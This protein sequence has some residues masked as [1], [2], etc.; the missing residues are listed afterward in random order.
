ML[1]GSRVLCHGWNTVPKC[2]PAHRAVSTDNIAQ[3]GGSGRSAKG[4]A[5]TPATENTK[6]S[7]H[8]FSDVFNSGCFSIT[9][10]LALSIFLS[11]SLI[12][13]LFHTHTYTRKMHSC[14][15][16]LVSYHSYLSTA[17]YH[18][19][20][21]YLQILSRLLSKEYSSRV[22]SLSLH[23]YH[24]LDLLRRQAAYISAGHPEKLHNGELRQKTYVRHTYA[25]WEDWCPFDAAWKL[26]FL[27]INLLTHTPASTECYVISLDRIARI[28]HLYFSI[29]ADA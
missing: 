6:D 2:Q 29:T 20:Q 22:K 16:M 26:T 7:S 18:I 8:H 4:R 13:S 14:V 19:G 5:K 15:W 10:L 12:L 27:D 21:F 23:K 1:Q 25:L 3:D 24:T 17:S 9:N 28:S 11:V